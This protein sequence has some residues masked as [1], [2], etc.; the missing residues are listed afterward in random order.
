[1]VNLKAKIRVKTKNGLYPVYI[2]FT[3][4]NQVSYVKTSWVVTEKGLNNKKEIIDPFVIQQTSILIENYYNQLNQVDTSNWSIQE[5]VKY[6]TEFNTDLSFSEYARK[7]I[8]KLI[9]R[10]QERTSRNY[11]WSLQHME[12]FAGTD[13]IM[14]SRLTSA[15]LNRWVESLSTTT[16]SK[17]Q[18]PVCMREVYKAAIREFNDEERGIVKLNNPWKNVTIPRSDVPE[19]RAIPASKLRAFFNVVPDRSRF[20][21][22]LMEVGQDVAL[23]SFCMC[24]LNAVDIFNAKKDQYDG[25]IFHYERQKTRSARSDRGYFEVRVPA[26]LKPTFVKYL[27]TD[28][29]SPW[30]FN[31]HDRLSTSD[32]FCANVNTGIKQIWEKVEPGYRA[33]LYAFRHSWATIA[34]N[35]CGATM[36]DVDFGLNH[37]INR[38]A[39]VYVKIDFTPAWILNEKVIDFVFFTEKESKHVEKEDKSFERI[40]RYNLVRAEAYVMGK[41][42]CAIEDTGYSNVDQIM[43]KLVTI[44]PKNIHNA[45]VQFK[46]TNVDKNLTQ[47]YQRL[48]P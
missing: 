20:T 24:G 9:N 14:F 25:C 31:F 19:K 15:F 47:M 40:S 30:L 3:K 32:S 10:G 16:R 17:E 6:V 34:Q 39:K 5:I 18:Y 42:V 12:R 21:N 4:Q 44:L 45:R 35:E 22:P 46:I 26:F 23:I 48:I 28:N 27:S 1:M 8:C 2:R 43:D 36:N 33:S 41:Q 7:H 37:S 13:N 29:N 11:K 38:M